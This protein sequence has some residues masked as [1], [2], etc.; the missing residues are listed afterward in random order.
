MARLMPYI[1]ELE[2]AVKNAHDLVQ[3]WYTAKTKSKLVRIFGRAV[4]NKLDLDELCEVSW[5]LVWLSASASK[6]KQ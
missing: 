4:R 6:C 3:R 2:M 5:E 1:T